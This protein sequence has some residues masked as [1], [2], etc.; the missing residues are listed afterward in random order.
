[1][2]SRNVVEDWMLCERRVNV[3]IFFF[4]GPSGLKFFM[5]IEWCDVTPAW[6]AWQRKFQQQ[7]IDWKFF[8]SGLLVPLSTRLITCVLRVLGVW[9]LLCVL[10]PPHAEP[11][12]TFLFQ[13][14]TK[15]IFHFFNFSKKTEFLRELSLLRLITY[16]LRVLGVWNLLCVLTPLMWDRLPHFCFKIRLKLSIFST[17]SKKKLNEFLLIPLTAQPYDFCS[18]APRGPEIC[19]AYWPPS[20]VIF[21]PTTTFLY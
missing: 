4:R 2:T 17:F 1:M 21:G 16:V 13:N 15:G 9:K 6:R 14:S 5:C 11:T 12:T 18:K 19:Y 7:K 10:D 8:F 3:R 20:C